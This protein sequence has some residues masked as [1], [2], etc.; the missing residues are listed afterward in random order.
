M[1]K[2][3]MPSTTTKRLHFA[4]LASLFLFFTCTACSMNDSLPR[5]M[6]L[7]AFNPHSQEFVCKHEVDVVPPI[8][9]E[10]EQWNLQAMAL[11]SSLLWPDQR[12]Y[13]GAVALW[14][15]AAERKHWKAMLN[16]ANAYAEGL[17]IEKDTEHAVQIVEQAMKLG[18][19]AAYDLM[20]TY[21]MNGVGVKQDASRAYAFWQIAADMGSPSAM[22]YL[23]SKMVG[24][25]D[26]PKTGFWGNRKI[27]LRML[28]CGVA[29][30]NAKAAFELGLTTQGDRPELNENNARAL[31]VLH[32]GVKFGGEESAAFLGVAFRT[33]SALVNGVQ[34]ANRADRYSILADRLRRDPDLR[35]PNLDKVVPLPPAPLPKWDG[36]KE[37]LINA[38][39]AVMLAP[40]VPAKQEPHPGTLRTGRAKV[41]AG[42]TL[43]EK[44]PIQVPPQAETTRAPVGG[45]WIAQLKYPTAERHF[46]WDAAQVPMHYKKDELFDRTRPG[47]EDEDGRIEFQY[48]GD[49]LPERLPQPP[50]SHSRV[51]QGV[52]REAVLPE[53]MVQCRGDRSCPATGIWQATVAGD[54]PVA[55]TFNQW[56]RQ[57][58]VAQGTTFP[59]PAELH[60][61][62]S[63]RDVT[64]TWWSEAN[65][66]GFAKLPQVSVGNPS[67]DA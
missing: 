64:W 39:K 25:Y 11:T 7:K 60:L 50:Q 10:S 61:N 41:P 16:L 3:S 24:T 12:D 22:A 45:Y 42:Y 46:A 58:Y 2:I 5:N 19:P 66:L 57:A 34:D 20:G 59:D 52:A 36:N 53:P 44:P 1:T 26:D 54:H 23:G 15:K 49:A 13:K 29:Q 37:T 43:P 67:N 62:V 9:P 40:V 55:A 8:A 48:V 33:G 30:G 31:G 51:A 17:G 6:S 56:Y 35:L 21:H 27:A 38:A 65:H 47:L 32:E 18:V 63:P 4:G 28:E 14:T